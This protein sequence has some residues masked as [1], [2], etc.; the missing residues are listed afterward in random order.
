[1][2]Y[3]KIRILLLSTLKKLVIPLF[4]ALCIPFLLGHLTGW[5]KFAGST[6]FFI[7]ILGIPLLFAYYGLKGP[8][9]LLLINIFISVPCIITAGLFAY[10]QTYFQIPFMALSYYSLSLLVINVIGAFIFIHRQNE[11]MVQSLMPLG[12]SILA[13]VLTFYSAGVGKKLSLYVFK[14]RL[15]QYEKLVEMIRNGEIKAEDNNHFIPLPDDYKGLA[16][17]AI[18]RKNEDNVIQ[19]S[20]SWGIGFPCK[21]TDYMY[22]SDG[23]KPEVSCGWSYEVIDN[24]YRVNY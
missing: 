15:P 6:A 8:E 2:P 16:H 19:I 11:Q 13:F 4:L 9:K 7:F 12:V 20:F 3:G 5:G 23:K 21:H 18:F 14:K 10:R 17:Y 1:M 22:C 24:W